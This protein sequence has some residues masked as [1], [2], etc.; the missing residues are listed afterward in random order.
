MVGGE[1]YK[2]L[3]VRHPDGTFV[4]ESHWDIP[5]IIVSLRLTTRYDSKGNKTLFIEEIQSDWTKRSS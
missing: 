1:N 3:L 2:E 5:G 4:D